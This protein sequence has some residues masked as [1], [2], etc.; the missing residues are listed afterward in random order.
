MLN[1]RQQQLIII[2][3]IIII[4]NTIYIAPI[5]SED[6][7]ALDMHQCKSKDEHNKM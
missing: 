7:E 6:T 5:K 3:I 1:L 2:I 4:I